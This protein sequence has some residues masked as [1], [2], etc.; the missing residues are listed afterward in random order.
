MYKNPVSKCRPDSIIIQSIHQ[1]L[2]SHTK[3]KQWRG[4]KIVGN[5][6]MRSESESRLNT[7]FYFKTTKNFTDAILEQLISLILWCT[8]S[9]QIILLH[10]TIDNI[11]VWQAPF[12]PFLVV[13]K[14]VVSYNLRH[15]RFGGAW[16]A[17]WLGH[18]PSGS[19]HDPRVPGSSPA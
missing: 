13:H 14:I 17:Q 8:F 11:I 5:T 1:C 7:F 18:L 2:H 6:W 10:Q 16:V 19:G 9:P 4:E 15:S 3:P 12:F